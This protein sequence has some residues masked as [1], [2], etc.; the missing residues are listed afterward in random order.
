MVRV[1]RSVAALSW[2]LL[3]AGCAH[4][5]A[6]PGVVG[7]PAAWGPFARECNHTRAF[8]TLFVKHGAEASAETNYET[9]TGFSMLS[10]AD[11]AA[12][13]TASTN[14]S[15]GTRNTPVI[16]RLV[17]LSDGGARPARVG[18]SGLLAQGSDDPAVAA[19]VAQ[20]ISAPR[21]KAGPGETLSLPITLPFALPVHADLSCRPSGGGVSAG[22]PVRVLSC[23]LDQ[24]IH[25]DV[26]DAQLRLSGAAEIDVTTGVRTAGH[27][28]GRLIGRARFTGTPEWQPADYAIRYRSSMDLE[29]AQ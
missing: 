3:A 12:G 1:T 4:P 17:R 28:E 18:D 13:I 6:R 9:C 29:D 7:A 15:N 23:A 25:D 14:M 27:L 20:E 26:L 8:R 2:C 21:R 24:A 11:G 10:G 5:Q 19:M 16:S 22:R